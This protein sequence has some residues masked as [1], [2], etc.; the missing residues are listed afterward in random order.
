MS[1]RGALIGL[2]AVVAS[3][4]AQAQPSTSQEPATEAKP[5]EATCRAY[6]EEGLA[7]TNLDEARELFHTA[8]LRC[9]NTLSLVLI[10]RT[11]EQQG[12]FARALAYI[13]AFLAVA[14]QGHESRPAMEKAAAAFRERVP[15]AQ[16]VNIA[17]ELSQGATPGATSSA[18]STATNENTT[19]MRLNREVEEVD[20][21]GPAI[22][23]DRQVGR[24]RGVFIGANLAYATKA[25]IEIHTET[26]D[27]RVAFPAVFAAELQAG[28]RFL[29]FLSVALAPQMLFNL[30]PDNE[31]SAHE[32][33]VFVQTTG[34]VAL[35]SQW[36][37]NVYV[38]PGYSVLIVPDADSAK[39]L[40][41]RWGGGPMFHL[42]EHISLAGEFSHQIGFQKTER[43]GGDVD[44]QTT[45]VS[46]LA[47]IRVRL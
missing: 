2:V 4:H 45:F 27:G 36:D 18:T 30:K 38:A 34:H 10:A 35:K 39:G 26:M 31:D 16:R 7:K 20:Y 5:T 37:F 15:A 22:R 14:D 19:R 1:T 43:D 9:A 13:E 46:L 17:A 21:A 25:A 11:Y 28:Y 23:A 8:R 3:S 42:S 44:M 33:A 12:D 32:L 41:F 40:A 24:A 6:V 29:P 47:G